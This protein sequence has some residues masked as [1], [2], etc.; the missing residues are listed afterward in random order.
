MPAIWAGFAFAV[1]LT[2][3]CADRASPTDAAGGGTQNDTPLATTASAGHTQRAVE[4]AEKL[5]TSP[6]D[7]GAAG[8]GGSVVRVDEQGRKWL[9]EI[10]YDVWFDD[11]RSIVADEPL[12]TTAQPVATESAP[13]PIADGRRP[14]EATSAADA[15]AE[16]EIEW[17]AV[18]SADVLD[19]EVKQA[20]NRLAGSM[21]SVGQFNRD[22]EQVR[23]HGGT[24]AAL[25]A[26]AIEHPG[27]LRWKDNAGYVRDVGTRIEEAAA[28]RGRDAYEAAHT[29]FL[30]LE[31]ILNGVVPA[32]LPQPQKR[33]DFADCAERGTLMQ[34][35]EQAYEWLRENVTTAGTL[36][37]EAHAASHEASLL[38][39]LGKVVS[40]ESYSLSDE[41]TYAEQSGTLVHSAARAAGAATEGK[42]DDFSAA[43]NDLQNSCTACHAEY[44]F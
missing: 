5:A 13:A 19:E 39:A 37:Q 44:R 17:Q 2:A 36:K 43:M 34:R 12:V 27:S 42:F 1:I 14:A 28:A 9:G 24:L 11:P 4:K 3:G 25:G 29:A 15:A 18:V 26:I 7:G 31:T 35:I 40:A 8:E 16:S 22:Y 41:P 33:R 32:D 23:V 21:R 10:P 38:A 6:K 20:H 30:Q